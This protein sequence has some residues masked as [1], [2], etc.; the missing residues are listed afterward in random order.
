MSQEADNPSFRTYL[1]MWLRWVHGRQGTGYD[2]LLLLV[3]PFPIP[4]D[5]YLSAIPKARKFRLTP[6]R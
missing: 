2:K 6:T 3:T 5:V 4:M 1:G